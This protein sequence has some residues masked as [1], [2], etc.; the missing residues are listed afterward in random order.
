MTGGFAK[1]PDVI[2][3]ANEVLERISA[4]RAK[5]RRSMSPETDSLSADAA[6]AIK[7]LKEYASKQYDAGY[8][9]GKISAFAQVSSRICGRDAA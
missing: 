4:F 6:N 2:V 1:T 3:R 5:W 7:D 8:Q 9:A